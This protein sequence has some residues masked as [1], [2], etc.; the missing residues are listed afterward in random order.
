MPTSDCEPNPN[1]VV[2]ESDYERLLEE[3]PLFKRRPEERK[4]PTEDPDD[5]DERT[6]NAQRS[7]QGNGFEVESDLKKR[8]LG[9]EELKIASLHQ[10]SDG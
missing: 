6:K 9:E 8:H 5:L 10:E 1:K 3:H 2:E 4:E 7:F